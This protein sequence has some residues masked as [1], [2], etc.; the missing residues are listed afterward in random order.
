MGKS[1]VIAGKEKIIEYDL[2]LPNE[3]NMENFIAISM[4][5]LGVISVYAIEKYSEVK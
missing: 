4:V 1:I 3:I 5:I 2:Y